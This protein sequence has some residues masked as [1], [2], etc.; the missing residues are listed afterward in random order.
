MTHIWIA[1]PSLETYTQLR[2]VAWHSGPPLRRTLSRGKACSGQKLVELLGG[3]PAVRGDLVPQVLDTAD[4]DGYTCETVVFDSRSN[5]SVYGY[6]LLPDGYRSPGPAVICLP[7]H[8]RGV[9]DIVGI[10]E[11]GNMRERPGRV[12]ADFALQCVHQGY[13]VLA[14][15]QL[16]FGHRRDAAARGKGADA[17]SCQPAAGAALLLGQTMIGW[18]VWD[19][20]RSLD[21]LATRPEVDVARVSVMGLSGGGTTALFSAAS[22]PRIK[23]SVVSGYFNTFRDSIFGLDHCMDNYVPGILEYAEMYDIAGLIAPRAL[24]VESG[25]H[26]RIFPVDATR[27]AFGQAQEVFR[28]FGAEDRL[29]LEVF[30]GAHEFNGAGAFQFLARVL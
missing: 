16:G 21:Y 27:Y 11:D 8:G 5:L 18:R 22:E 1:W 28:V 4:F 24:F 15:E 20:V 17:S 9:D 10:G 7:G 26:D 2:P 25:T 19:V 23:A 6:F 30:E 12:Q 3:F 29:G 13:A 14:I